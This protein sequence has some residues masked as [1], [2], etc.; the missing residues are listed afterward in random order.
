MLALTRLYQK[1]NKTFSDVIKDIADR[2][3]AFG[4]GLEETYIKDKVLP[5]MFSF[6]FMTTAEQILQEYI[7]GLQKPQT[8]KEQPKGPP[9]PPPADIN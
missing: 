2:L 7:Q 1:D 5:W 6:L 4:M 9:F 3:N 8:R